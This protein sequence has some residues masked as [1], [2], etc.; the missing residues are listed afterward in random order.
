MK[1]ASL[2]H[3]VITTIVVSA[4]CAGAGAKAGAYKQT[5][6]VSDIPGLAP[7]T[8]PSLVNPWGVSF[9]A[10]SPFWVSNQGTS[11]ST[12]YAV[13]GTTAAK[14]GL[15]VG[16]PPG[17]SPFLGPTGQVANTNPLSFPVGN[18]GNGGPAHFIFA[19][20]NGTI[21]AWDTPMTPSSFIQ[22]TTPGASYTGL[23]INHTDT[24]L[25]AAN[26]AAG[27]IDVFNSA[28]AQISLGLGAFATP[29]SFGTLVPFNVQD[30]GGN[31][32]VTYAPPGHPAQTTAALGEG[33]VAEFTE[34][35]VLEKTLDGGQ[36]AAPWG[37]TFAPSGWGPFGGDLLV[38]NFSYDHSEINA[39]NPTTWAFEGSIG[40]NPGLGDT[41]G[42]LWA[43]DFGGMGNNG[44]PNILY[45][46][47]G[48]N[49]ETAGLFGA[50]SVPEPST[51]AMMLVGLGGLGLAAGRRRRPPRAIG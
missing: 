18:G 5:D 36:L 29:A 44:S 47:D 33:A 14:L 6:L 4:A 38:G 2:K 51:W 27:A 28:F 50:F 8:D 37:V 17:G 49:G 34:G 42:G 26:D 9:F 43:L 13:T 16:I 1:P 15:T 3:L 32:F 46:T 30:I 23:A 10:G 12:L 19:N 40:I 39:F 41:A 25:F 20:L 35:G 24:E 11:T 21:S 45:F 7:V 48:L 22:V 31:V